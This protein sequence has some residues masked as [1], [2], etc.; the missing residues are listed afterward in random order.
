M[1][2][3]IL[4]NIRR[5]NISVDQMLALEPAIKKVGLVTESEVILGLPGETY[6]TQINTLRKLLAAKLDSIQVYTCMLINGSELNTPEQRKKWNFKT[7]FRILPRDF[8][9]L[10][11]GK[12]VIET[13]EVIVGSDT[14]SFD[15]YLELRLLAFSIFVTNIGIIYDSL[16]KFLRQNDIEIFDLFFQMVKQIDSASPIVQKTF[17]SFKNDTVEELW[18]SPEDIQAHY[19]EKQEYEKLLSGEAARNVMQYHNALVRYSCMDEW[20]QFAGNIAFGLLK[21]KKTISYEIEHQL[22]NI[23]NFCTGSGH[24]TLGDDRQQTNPEFLFDYDIE[25]WIK[26]TNNKTLNDFK[27]DKKRSISFQF[28]EDES[29]IIQDELDR[30]NTPSGRSQALKRLHG[31]IQWRHPN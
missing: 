1:D 16:L 15:E 18:D 31:Q 17:E 9:T 11:N 8:T 29:K 12:N 23:I 30:K 7:K 27:L 28:T 4:Q 24:N 13:E 14:L 22:K 5:S 25:N 10:R 3:Q 6:Q 21:K 2:E 26:D 19:Q 20:T